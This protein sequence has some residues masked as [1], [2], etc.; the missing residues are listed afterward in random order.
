MQ[1][2]I[3]RRHKMAKITKEELFNILLERYGELKEE[4][5][6]LSSYNIEEDLCK[7]DEEI[8]RWKERWDRSE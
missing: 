5:L 2:A 7:L 1:E 8:N 4:M 6:D 3:I